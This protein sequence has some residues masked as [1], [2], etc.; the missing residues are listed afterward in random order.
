M[1]AQKELRL[2]RGLTLVEVMITLAIF[3]V[4]MT[5]FMQF[6]FGS[7]SVTSQVQI[8]AVLKTNSEK[9]LNEI[10][11]YLSQSKKLFTRSSSSE[12]YLGKLDLS[13]AP[14]PVTYR[15]L[16]DIRTSGALSP[17]K[18]CQISP[19]A[20]FLPYSFGNSLFFAETLAP[21]QF[22][23]AASG[24]RRTIDVYR[25]D[26]VYITDNRTDTNYLTN[27]PQVK[28]NYW[29][30]N[31]RYAQNLILWQSKA[32]A[33]HQ[34]L[35]ELF[36]SASSDQKTAAASALSAMGIDTA[37]KRSETNPN[38]AFYTISSSTLTKNDNA[39]KVPMSRFTDTLR[40]Q[41]NGSEVYSVS[42]NKNSTSSNPNV[43]GVNFKVPMYYTPT[44]NTSGCSD[45][46][47]APAFA[48]DSAY[49]NFPGGFEV[50]IAGPQS[51]RSVM[52]HLSMI[53]RTT[54]HKLVEQAFTTTT[55]ARDL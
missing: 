19:S 13:K 36:T 52:M 18:T 17:E 50:G 53:A 15:Q 32:L 51:G 47:A 21:L 25:F 40:L 27:R 38:D 8:R 10:S 22:Y 48:S 46:P 5:M 4:I 20:Y 43:F 14:P 44:Y 31:T 33:D 42:Y 7:W 3:A 49:A 29:G 2:Q 26:Y 35:Q 45:V 37:W 24:L 12:N 28:V 11:R 55:Y 6:L 9:G 39:Y 1:P 34:Q 23:H 30:G 41:N 16:P 54:S